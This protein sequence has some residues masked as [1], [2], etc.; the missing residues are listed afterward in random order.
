LRQSCNVSRYYSGSWRG[1]L[2]KIC[3]IIILEINYILNWFILEHNTGVRLLNEA[4]G[5]AA[6]AAANFN[7]YN[8]SWT[9]PYK[10]EYYGRVIINK[11]INNISLSFEKST[12]H[13]ILIPSYV[14]WPLVTTIVV[15]SL[16]YIWIYFIFIL[17]VSWFNDLQIESNE[18][19]ITLRVQKTITNGFK[20]FLISEVMIFFSL[21]WS[22]IHLGLVPNI[23]ILMN[24]PP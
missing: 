13:S 11:S 12:S 9:I 17:L 8:Y 20:I 19:R 5:A 15:Y 1:E 24:F 22:F 2:F 10:I 6:E 16:L 23:F 18:G 4:A 14:R 3:D 7:S 21:I